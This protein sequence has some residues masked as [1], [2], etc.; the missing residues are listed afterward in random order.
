MNE[1]GSMITSSNTVRND[2]EGPVT[3]ESLN[4]SAKSHEFNDVKEQQAVINSDS[5][6]VETRIPSQAHSPANELAQR[7][8][9]KR[10]FS[11]IA[12]ASDVDQPVSKR[13][14]MT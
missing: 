5:Q 4:K 9:R 6:H 7:P 10:K 1:P 14:R 2:R 8:C 13:L 3:S 12:G 11:E